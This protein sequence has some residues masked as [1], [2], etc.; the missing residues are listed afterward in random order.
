MLD[1]TIVTI[2]DYVK[3]KKYLKKVYLL[4]NGAGHSNYS[5]ENVIKLSNII[6]RYDVIFSI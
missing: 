2:V 4:T 1:K 5:T 3:T 6:E